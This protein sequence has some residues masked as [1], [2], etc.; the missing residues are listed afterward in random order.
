MGIYIR[1]EVHR[2]VLPCVFR[3]QSSV[4]PDRVS[5]ILEEK[6]NK[7]KKKLIDCVCVYFGFPFPCC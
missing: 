2:R 7:K 6:E 5:N 4:E 3:D 1:G